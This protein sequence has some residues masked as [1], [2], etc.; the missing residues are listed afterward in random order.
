M[1]FKTMLKSRITERHAH[2]EDFGACRNVLV[3]SIASTLWFSR[4]VHD[5]EIFD[6]HS[7]LSDI[8][9]LSNQHLWAFIR[10]VD[11]NRLPTA[12]LECHYLQNVRDRKHTECRCIDRV[13]ASD[14]V[15]NA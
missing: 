2:V 5:T 14:D 9:I 1:C 12:E 10:H 8:G 3:V 7:G 6:A 11:W 13:H 15:I 4:H